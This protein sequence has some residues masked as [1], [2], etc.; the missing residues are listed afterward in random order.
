MRG[1]G[2]T[3]MGWDG[4]MWWDNGRGFGWDSGMDNGLR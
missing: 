3:V 2:D 1:G 4:I